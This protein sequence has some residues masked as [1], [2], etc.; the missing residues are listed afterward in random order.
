MNAKDFFFLVK[1]MREQQ[2]LYFQT[3]DN[4]IKDKAIELEKKVDSE[5][6]TTLIKKGLKEGPGNQLSLNFEDQQT[7]QTVTTWSPSRQVR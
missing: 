2:R 5:I 4:K 3:R 7:Q 1:A 6:D